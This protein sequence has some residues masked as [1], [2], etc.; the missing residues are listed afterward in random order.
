[1][2]GGRRGNPEVMYHHPDP[3]EAQEYRG[4]T[5]EK[6]VRDNLGRGEKPERNAD[7]ERCDDI[8][9]QKNLN[10]RQKKKKMAYNIYGQNLGKGGTQLGIVT[11]EQKRNN[12]GDNEG[13]T[14][15]KFQMPDECRTNSLDS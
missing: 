10:P 11:G 15:A 13:N 8:I 1:M 7:G 2:G 12:T 3:P 4:C 6:G 14:R 5:Q 9:V